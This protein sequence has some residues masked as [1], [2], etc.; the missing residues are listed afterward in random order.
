[1]TMA[2]ASYDDAKRDLSTGLNRPENGLLWRRNDD[3]TVSFDDQIDVN[4]V[5]KNGFLWR[6]HLYFWGWWVGGFWL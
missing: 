4:G 3:K 6:W 5:L 1:M 2:T